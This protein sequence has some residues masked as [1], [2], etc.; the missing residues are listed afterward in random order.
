MLCKKKRVVYVATDAE[1][2]NEHYYRRLWIAAKNVEVSRRDWLDE[3]ADCLR[4]TCDIEILYSSG[5]SYP[6]PYVD[7]VFDDGEMRWMGEFLRGRCCGNRPRTTS[8]KIERVKLIDLYFRI[9]HPTIAQHFG[10]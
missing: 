8:R 3:I 7:D 10:R 4:D 6:I 9:K 5:K 2:L 1:I